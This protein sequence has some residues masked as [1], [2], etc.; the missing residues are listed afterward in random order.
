[1]GC[2][3]SKEAILDAARSGNLADLR[4][5]LDSGVSVDAKDKVRPSARAQSAALTRSPRWDA[6]DGL[7]PLHLAADEGHTEC[8]KLLLD[9]G[10]DVN[11]KSNVRPSARAQP[12]AL[13]HSPRCTG[14]QD[15]ARLG[16]G[17]AD[18]RASLT[19]SAGS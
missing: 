13:T 16:E 15:G 9:K 11:A 8:A 7:T 2:V 18:A 4:R 19:S 1:M 14:G 10:A 12:A 3:S 6:Q 17:R 5:L